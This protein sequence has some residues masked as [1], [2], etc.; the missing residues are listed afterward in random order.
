MLEKL[1]SRLGRPIPDVKVDLNEIYYHRELLC[2]SL[3]GRRVDLVTVSSHH[4]LT[5][6][7]EP[8]LPGLFL[9]S[10]TPRARKFKGKKVGL[11]IDVSNTVCL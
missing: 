11:C 6:N 3:E 2:R 9:D 10:D 4:G 5:S 8:R 7:E 1:D